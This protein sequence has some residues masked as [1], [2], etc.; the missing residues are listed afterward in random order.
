AVRRHPHGHRLPLPA[1]A[2]LALRVHRSL[3]PHALPVPAPSCHGRGAEARKGRAMV[4]Y[5]RSR[6]TGVLKWCGVVSAAF[7][8]MA[9][10]GP[11]PAW[12]VSAGPGPAGP[13][14]LLLGR[15]CPGPGA[16]LAG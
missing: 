6:G 2:G 1:V 12:T 4:W 7:L 9:A 15:L 3:T 11:A 16:R 8:V 13:D 14:G 10:A 5:A